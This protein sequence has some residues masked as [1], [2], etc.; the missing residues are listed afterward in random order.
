MVATLERGTH[1]PRG[2]ERDVGTVETVVMDNMAHLE[3]LR[4]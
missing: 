2:T 1:T 3:I 4:V